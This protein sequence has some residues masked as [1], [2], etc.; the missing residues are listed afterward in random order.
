MTN[1]ERF[2]SMTIDELAD[3]LD[4]YATFDQ[5]PHM[6]WFTE[7]YCENCPA[8]MVESE[9]SDR[10]FLC[11]WCE[12]EKKCK[13]F[14]GREEVPNNRD[15]IKLWLEKEVKKNEVAEIR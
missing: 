12:L 9:A 15:I 13:F 1:F 5:A 2:A 11:S 3:W 6:L 7:T 4:E 14:P 8:V 10:E